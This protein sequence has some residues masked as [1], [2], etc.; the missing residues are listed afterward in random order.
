M[1]RLSNTWQLAKCSWVVLR[2]D[3]ELV[4]LPVMGLAIAL[5]VGGIFFGPFAA[6]VWGGDDSSIP[7]AGYLL[8]FAGYVAVA[9][10]MYFFQAAVVAGAHERMEGGDPTVGSAIGTARRHAP[11]IVGWALIASTVSIV[12]DQLQERFGFLGAI[13]ASILDV[14]WRVTTFL[15]LP[16]VVVEG[17][18][19]IQG[20]KRSGSLLKATWGERIFADVG[21]GLLGM[22][23]FLP[24]VLV[25]VLAAASGV[26]VVAIVGI[27]AAVVYGLTVW[28]GMSAL[29]A[30]YQVALHRY[31]TDRPL[32]PPFD[33]TTL[34]R[35]IRQR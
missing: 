9:A 29:S 21:F 16:V 4:W 1:S 11:A 19:P 20:V 3:R 6:L 22:L 7:L 18:G 30:V 35:T 26:L 5:V 10:I 13:M 33:E 25:G 2:Q 8:A 17:T 24:A 34:S 28:A 15:V 12:L 32:P 31:A 23:L 27:A 14:A